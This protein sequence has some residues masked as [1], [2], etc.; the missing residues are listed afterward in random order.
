ME[1]RKTRSG[2]ITAATLPPAALVALAVLAAL[3]ALTAGCSE[4]GGL[5]AVDRPEES[6]GIFFDPAGRD[7]A[8]SIA[9]GQAFDIYVV[10]FD[11]DDPIAFSIFDIPALGS[12]AVAVYDFAAYPE[13]G[14]FDSLPDVVDSFYLAHGP[15][16]R[17]SGAVPLLRVTISISDAVTGMSFACDGSSRV[18]VSGCSGGFAAIRYDGTTGCLAPATATAARADVAPA[19]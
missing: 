11:V 14:G 6:V 18:D 12:P 4:D 19:D 1:R 5:A 3:T 2:K 15:G 16:L 7:T 17:G 8:L 10:A 9:A 13:G